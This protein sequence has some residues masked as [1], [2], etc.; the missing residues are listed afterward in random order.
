MAAVMKHGCA[1]KY[2][3]EELGSS[4]GIV[5]AAVTK[6]GDA[7]QYALEEMRSIRR[8]GFLGVPHLILCPLDWAMLPCPC[9]LRQRIVRR[10]P[11]GLVCLWLG[12]CGGTL[13]ASSGK[14]TIPAASLN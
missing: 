13:T 11:G 6:S 5:M 12:P 14:R 10:K 3:S 4:Q 2:A 1:L 7:L 9:E 8:C